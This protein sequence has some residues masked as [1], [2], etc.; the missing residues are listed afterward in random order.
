M[1]IDCANV[2]AH[3]LPFTNINDNIFTEINQI[4][5]KVE[6]LESNDEQMNATFVTSI[7]G[8]FAFF[9]TCFTYIIVQTRTYICNL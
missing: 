4:A 7:E 6:V 3:A 9:T 1:H 8:N 5:N 2:K